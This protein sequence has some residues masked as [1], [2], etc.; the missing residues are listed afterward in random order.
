MI[1]LYL[2]WNKGSKI[3][4]F[5]GYSLRKLSWGRCQYSIQQTYPYSV[6]YMPFSKLTWVGN[7]SLWNFL[8][9]YNYFNSYG[10]FV[11]FTLGITIQLISCPL[12]SAFCPCNPYKQ[13]KT[14]FFFKK[15]Y[16]VLVIYVPAFMSMP[17]VWVW[18]EVSRGHQIPWSWNSRC[19]PEVN[20][21]NW[22]QV[23]WNSCK[24][25]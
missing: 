25:S 15:M 6:I 5:L 7:T 12:A 16:F 4:H 18:A 21:G 17:S 1:C 2:I 13:N 8:F 9:I 20:N 10:F 11:D 19:L 3:D 14:F 22:T 24:C 23:F